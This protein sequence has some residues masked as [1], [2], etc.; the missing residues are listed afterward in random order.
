M[1]CTRQVNDMRNLMVE[2]RKVEVE[3]PEGG[4]DTS[5]VGLDWR[6]VSGTHTS[7]L[8]VKRDLQG[9]QNGGAQWRSGSV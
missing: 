2:R 7:A 5:R 4:S 1:S 6:T 9:Q 8:K 3:E